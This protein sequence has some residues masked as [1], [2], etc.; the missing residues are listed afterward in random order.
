MVEHSSGHHGRELSAADLA[1]PRRRVYRDAHLE[2]EKVMRAEP[3]DFVLKFLLS[4]PAVTC[5]I[6]GTSRPKHMRDNAMVG[7]GE[8]PG[9][10]FWKTRMK[11]LGT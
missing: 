5:V 3:L 4:H 11:D 1:G 7:H 10:D 6:P 9:R 2:L 8:L